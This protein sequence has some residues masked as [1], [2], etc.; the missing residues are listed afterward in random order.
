MK[1]LLLA[2]IL[3]LLFSQ[4]Q[5]GNDGADSLPSS[6][7]YPVPKQDGKMMF[8]IQRTH[9][10]N[11]VIYELN[12]RKD[13][14]VDPKEPLTPVWIRFEEGGARKPLSLIQNRVFGLDMRPV[15]KATWMVH[16]RSYKKRDIFL[17]HTENT[18]TFRAL[19]RI[20]GKMAELSNLFLCMV[21]NALGIPSV[22]KYIDIFG[23]DPVTREQ[24][25]ERVTP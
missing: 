6:R 4:L 2:T 23:V 13:G 17:I 10:R 19:V 5:A 3:M 25:M 20:N 8:Y 16:F 24:V 9:N 22:I 12:F 18:N 7:K 14:S 15:V 1:R 11:T 21:T